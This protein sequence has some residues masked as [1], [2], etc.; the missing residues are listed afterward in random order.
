M[1]LSIEF[2]RAMAYKLR[3]GAGMPS[4]QSSKKL[5]KADIQAIGRNLPAPS[6]VLEGVSRSP[7]VDDL[8]QITGDHALGD[9]YRADGSAQTPRIHPDSTQRSNNVSPVLRA[10]QDLKLAQEILPDMG[11]TPLDLSGSSGSQIGS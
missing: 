10:T 3:C 1:A 4:A 6:T 11:S 5:T 9:W 2:V 8:L 7:P